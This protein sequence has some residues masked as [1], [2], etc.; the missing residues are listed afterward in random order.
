MAN[1]KKPT[2]N[3]N[4]RIVGF[5]LA[6]D[7]ARDVKAEAAQRDLSLRELFEELWELYRQKH[8]PKS[9]AS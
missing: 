8:P 7:R 4:R 5:S 9:P 6:P 2:P 3:R 1:E